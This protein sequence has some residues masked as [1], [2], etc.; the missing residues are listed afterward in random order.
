M[1]SAE[2]ARLGRLRPL[3]GLAMVSV[4]A[5][6]WGTVG[7]ANGLMRKDIVFDPALIG[8]LRVG[9]GAILIFLIARLAGHPL[10]EMRRLPLAPLCLFGLSGAVFQICLFA[11]FARVGVT[12]TVAV[13][14]CAPP[15]IVVAASAL[16]RGRLPPG[17][18]MVALM[19]SVAGLAL[20]SFDPQAAVDAAGALDMVGAGLLAGASLAF[21]GISVAARA[22]CRTVPCLCV[23]YLGLAATGGVLAAVGLSRSSGSLVDL[24]M[25]EPRELALLAYIGFAA[26]GGAYCAFVTG[27]KLSSSAGVGLIATMTEPAIAAFLAAVLLR[28]T[29]SLAEAVGCALMLVA[30]LALFRS[31]LGTTSRAQRDEAISHSAG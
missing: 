9:M 3:A 12:V 4:A 20:V 21:V 17:W 10:P 27:M 14:V 25:L 16:R 26:T 30:M 24:T 28:E 31:E 11:A 7:V 22:A 6:L 5:C 19:L 23:T 15:M 1:I 13:T 29:L 2:M 18:T 8:M